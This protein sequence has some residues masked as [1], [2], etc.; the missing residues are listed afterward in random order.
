MR[1]LLGLEAGIPFL[2]L[3]PVLFPI[4]P[5]RV[6][7]IADDDSEEGGYPSCSKGG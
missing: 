1:F 3:G 7:Q 4:L 2:A 6:Q 5:I